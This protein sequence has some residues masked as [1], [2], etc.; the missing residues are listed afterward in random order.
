[1]DLLTPIAFAVAVAAVLAADILDGGT[2]RSLINL[3]A[4]ILVLAGTIGAS[5]MSV[6]ARDLKA[7][8]GFFAKVLRPQSTSVEQAID[9][10]A[11]LAEVARREGF[12]RLDDA[13][14]SRHVAPFLQRGVQLVVDG[15]DEGRLRMVMEQE[16]AIYEARESSGA[17]FFQTAGGFAPTLGI[18]GTVVGLVSVLTNLSDVQKLAPS[19]A[20]A[21][22]ATLWGISSANFFW[23]P[24]GYKIKNALAHELQAREMIIEGCIA[25]AAGQNPRL[26]IEQLAVYKPDRGKGDRAPGA[27]GEEQTSPQMIGR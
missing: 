17:L 16:L 24:I 12:L 21:F 19:I 26:I 6:A 9:D 7:I 23:L 15:A 8:P 27:P 18:I 22:I 13:L 25:I 20:T 11:A 5:I 2:I 10:I 4:M 14:L 1:M 3:P